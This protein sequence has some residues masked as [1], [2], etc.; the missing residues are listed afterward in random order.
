M[1]TVAEVEIAIEALTPRQL[2]ALRRR[3]ATRSEDLADLVAHRAALKA[4]NFT[5]WEEVKRELHALPDLPRQGR[6][7]VS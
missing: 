5:P 4:G 2:R 1:P 3:L 7:K 6:A